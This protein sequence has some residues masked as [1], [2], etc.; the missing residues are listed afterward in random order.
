MKFK[1]WIKLREIAINTWLPPELDSFKNT[2][3]SG[4]NTPL[5]GVF[6]TDELPL[7]SRRKIK[8]ISKK[9]HQ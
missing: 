4:Q 7:T 6:S 9:K 8:K 1:N 3:K 5:E 2:I